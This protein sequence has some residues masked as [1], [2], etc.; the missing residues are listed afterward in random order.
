VRREHLALLSAFVTAACVVP[1]L[2]DIRRGTTRPHRTS[3]FVFATLAL[4]AAVSQALADA[5]PGT[6]LAAG[7]AV[8]FGAV[9]IASIRRGVGGSSVAD[10]VARAVAAAGAVASVV[11]ARPML[12]VGGV[13][14]AEIG[15]A[16]LT[17]RK[18]L[19]D[20]GSETRSTWTADA[21]AGMLAI[22]AVDQLTA[23]SLLY[24]IHHVVAN[25][26]VVAAIVIG[27]RRSLSLDVLSMRCPG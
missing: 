14:V 9:F 10:H 26:A 20:P 11:T 19:R 4:V 3:W 27:H 8:G 18:T 21:V 23:A 24:P 1:Y 25:V 15:A 12:A 17:V 16:A 2:R 5:G 6:W 13:V 7:S 22:G